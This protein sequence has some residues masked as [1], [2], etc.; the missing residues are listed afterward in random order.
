MVPYESD[1]SYS[2]HTY[3]YTHIYT[4]I[5]IHL[6]LTP[7]SLL[8]HPRLT[9]YLSYLS[10][11]SHLLILQYPFSSTSPLAA[12]LPINLSSHPPLTLVTPFTLILRP[13]VFILS[14]T[15]LFLFSPLPHLLTYSFYPF[16]VIIS[17]SSYRPHFFL[18]PSHLLL[19]S[20]F[21]PVTLFLISPSLYPGNP[22]LCS[23]IICSPFS[24]S[25]Y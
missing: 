20:P 4:Y 14:H 1:L 24:G 10:Y 11:Y 25:I 16:I 23:L 6:A 3:T 21:S 5:Y 22:H 19:L 18:T 2:I 8:S 15:S 9:S 12:F 7:A 13:V 17:S